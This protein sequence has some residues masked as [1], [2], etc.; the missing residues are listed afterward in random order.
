MLGMQNKIKDGG[1]KMS[2]E[3]QITK[4]VDK[5]MSNGIFNSTHDEMVLAE[6]VMG[7][8]EENKKLRVT[9]SERTD[10]FMVALDKI[11]AEIE[12]LLK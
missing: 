1:R 3:Q 9:M 7:L 2:T 8:R 11:K 5:V 12:L 4:L 10:M 6:A